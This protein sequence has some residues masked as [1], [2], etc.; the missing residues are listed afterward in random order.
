MSVD[1]EFL[2]RRPPDRDQVKE[3]FTTLEF[4]TLLERL[5]VEAPAPQSRGTY[6]TVAADALPPLL[7]EAARLAIAPVAGGYRSLPQCKPTRPLSVLEIHGTA[8]PVVPYDGKPPDYSTEGGPY[9]RN[10]PFFVAPTGMTYANG[11]FLFCAYLQS[12]LTGTLGLR[13]A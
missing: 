7:A 4:K 2:R 8:D 1:L 10:H 11:H 12:Y 5:G 9:A 6:R 3:L 13:R